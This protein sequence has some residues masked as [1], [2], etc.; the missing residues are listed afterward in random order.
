ME[1]RISRDPAKLAAQLKQAATG[2]GNEP[3][4]PAS[5]PTAAQLLA[6][7]DDIV[8]RATQVAKAE[9]DVARAKQELA[10]IAAA[11][12]RNAGEFHD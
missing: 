6:L 10:D 9:E 12:Q 2:I 4:W 11:A 7:H 1:P 5:A 3:A 8:Q